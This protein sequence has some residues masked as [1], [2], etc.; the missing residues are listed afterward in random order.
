MRIISWNVNGL[1]AVHQKG[2]FQPFVDEHAPDVLLLQE[3]K[4]HVDHL[5]VELRELSGYQ[6]RVQAAARKGYSGVAVYTR[7]APDE[8]I[9]GLG[10]E[11]FDQEARLLG[12]R[13]GDVV[14]LSVYFPNSQAAGARLPYRLEFGAALRGMLGGLRERGL[15]PVLCGDYNVAHRPIDLARPRPNEK[16]PGYLPEEREWMS[17]FL[18]EDGL[19]DTWRRAHP[20]TTEVYSWW[21]Y[22]FAARAKNIGWRLDYCCVDEALWPRVQDPTI[23]TEVMGSDHCPVALTVG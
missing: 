13:F 15:H 17:A 2:L 11:A 18:A 9:D 4:A 7:A 8:W 22:R 20:E 6:L 3:T 1:R 23:L 10:I 21:S 14:A 12:A 19:V 16:N 5:P